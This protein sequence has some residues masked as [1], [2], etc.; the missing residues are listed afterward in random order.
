[1]TMNLY[2]SNDDEG[3]LGKI[4]RCELELEQCEENIKQ[5]LRS[6]NL[7]VSACDYNQIRKNYSLKCYNLNENKTQT[8]VISSDIFDALCSE[9]KYSDS[10]GDKIKRI[11]ICYEII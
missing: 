1:M 7:V 10:L 3:I 4:L 8:E 5:Q 2:L 11:N 6:V 9:K